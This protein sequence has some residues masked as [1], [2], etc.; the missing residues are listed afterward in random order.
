MDKLQPVV[1]SLDVALQEQNAKAR[2]NLQNLDAFPILS[3][4]QKLSEKSEVGGRMSLFRPHM[5]HEHWHC[6]HDFGPF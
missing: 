6:G 1:F 3:D 2:R 5:V 4:K